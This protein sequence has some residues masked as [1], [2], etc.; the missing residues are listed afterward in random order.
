MRRRPGGDGAASWI[1]W[2]S[3]RSE[4][5]TILDV[6]FAFRGAMGRGEV[7]LKNEG[8]SWT[9]RWF[10]DGLSYR[11]SI[12]DDLLAASVEG[13]EIGQELATEALAAIRERRAGRSG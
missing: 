5:D 8:R 4:M 7:W 9:L 2:P 3:V 10:G 11:V 1:R 6:Y 13:R 12:T